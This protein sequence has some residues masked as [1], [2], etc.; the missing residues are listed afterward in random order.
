VRTL[1]S[2]SSCSEALQVILK[3]AGGTQHVNNSGSPG[4]KKVWRAQKRYSGKH[5]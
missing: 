1:E 5:A 2:F 4:L 3:N